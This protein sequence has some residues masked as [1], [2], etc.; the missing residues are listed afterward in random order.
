MAAR[1]RTTRPQLAGNM[2]TNFMG[3]TQQSLRLNLDGKALAASR[4]PVPDLQVTSQEELGHSPMDA[5]AQTDELQEP[6]QEAMIP[7][8]LSINGAGNVMHS[9]KRTVHRKLS[10]QTEPMLM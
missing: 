2:S 6:G 5:A 1:R 7:A 8:R 9:T 10:R 4:M 3:S